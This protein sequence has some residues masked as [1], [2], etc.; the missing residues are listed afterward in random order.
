MVPIGA[1]YNAWLVFLCCKCAFANFLQN[2][3][4][5]EEHY[6]SQRVLIAPGGLCVSIM[7]QMEVFPDGSQIHH[8]NY[9]T[10]LA[11]W[12][13]VMRV[14]SFSL[15]SHLVVTHFPFFLFYWYWEKRLLIL[16]NLKMRTQ[17][18]KV[19]FYAILTFPDCN[20]CF[21]SAVMHLK[22][23]KSLPCTTFQNVSSEAT[24]Q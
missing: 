13:E 1:R 2:P 5:S 23:K 24:V 11:Q 20:M 4:S 12:E 16:K 9:S 6:S 15:C 8:W 14:E 7:T 17:E 19:P 18:L 22:M 10:L 21:E 3:G